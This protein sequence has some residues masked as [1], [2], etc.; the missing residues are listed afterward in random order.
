MQRLSEVDSSLLKLRTDFNKQLSAIE[1]DTHSFHTAMIDLSARNPDNKELIQFIVFVNDKLETKHKTH[2]EVMIEAFNELIDVKRSL[3]H[4]LQEVK[5][6]DEQGFFK[7][8][9]NSTKIFA[10]IKMTV[11]GV[12]AIA[13]AVVVMISPDIVL[14]VIKALATLILG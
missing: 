11:I 3:I 14:S 4:A 12:A 8:I 7:K 5:D 1:D 6:K 2:S 13:I 10:D 9:F